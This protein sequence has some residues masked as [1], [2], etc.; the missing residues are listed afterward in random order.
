MTKKEVDFSI[1][2]NENLK[3]EC[4]R[5]C[6]DNNITLTDFLK[7]FIE[8]T[9]LRGELPY[10]I[11][12]VN[13]TENRNCGKVSKVHIR[14]NNEE[15][16][17]EFKKVCETFFLSYSVAIKAYMRIC[18]EKKHIICEKKSSE[19]YNQRDYLKFKKNEGARKLKEALE[20]E[21]T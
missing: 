21:K 13:V 6:N 15:M 5:F 10:P 12:E 1:R 17:N 3:E 7:A 2:V 18:L 4:I 14:F 9:A 8:E 11:N 19:L 20:N 16:M